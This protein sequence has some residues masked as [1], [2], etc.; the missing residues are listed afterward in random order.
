VTAKVTAKAASGR[1]VMRAFMAG[2]HWCLTRM[3]FEQRNGRRPSKI[4]REAI[5]GQDSL[6]DCSIVL[7]RDRSA[8]LPHRVHGRSRSLAEE[9]RA[10]I[11]NQEVA[12]KP[13]DQLQLKLASS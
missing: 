13:L 4:G 7:L 9:I 12:D 2:L 1:A 6:R 11:R 8:N 10:Y 5:H 3:A